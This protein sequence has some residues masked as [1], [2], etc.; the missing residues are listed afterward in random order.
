MENHVIDKLAWIYIEDKKV[1]MARSHGQDAF[2]TPGGGR[3]VGESDEAA[4]IREIKEELLVDI[5]PES[6]TFYGTFTAP[7][8]G[9]PEGT[10]VQM[11]CYEAA[12]AGELTPDGEEIAE[13]A[14]FTS[15]DRDKL[16]AVGQLIFDDLLA[17]DLIV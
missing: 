1:L 14:W 6:I 11:T 10:V 12:Y 3:E 17:K 15:A 9:K 4:L 5:V 8:H 16:S 2:Y 13:F 7:A